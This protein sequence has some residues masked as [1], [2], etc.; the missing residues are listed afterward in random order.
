MDTSEYQLIEFNYTDEE[1]EQLDKYTKS[2]LDAIDKLIK[3]SLQNLTISEKNR[4]SNFETVSQI[5]EFKPLCSMYPMVVKY[6]LWMQLFSK[7]AFVKYMEW[8]AKVRPS[9]SVR[10]QYQED[11]RSVELWKNKYHYAV[12]VKYLYRYKYNPSSD[13]L[14]EIY[15]TTYEQLNSETTAMLDIIE[16]QQKQMKQTKEDRLEHMKDDIK[17]HLSLFVAN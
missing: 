14:N 12:Y 9:E 13:K 5:E 16:E 8:K 3:Y 1:K 17:K 4:V 15:K 11:K 10:L 2:A 6:V 7:K